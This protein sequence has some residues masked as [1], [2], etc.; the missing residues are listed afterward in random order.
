MTRHGTP[1][2]VSRCTM[3]YRGTLCNVPCMVFHACVVISTMVARGI[4]HSGW[5]VMA[6]QLVVTETTTNERIYVIV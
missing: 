5:N 2:G 4:S 1:W 3:T 6:L